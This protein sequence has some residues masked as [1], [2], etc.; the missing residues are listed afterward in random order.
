M[1]SCPKMKNNIQREKRVISMMIGIYCKKKHGPSYKNNLCP[2]CQELQAYAHLRLSHC[3]YGENKGFCSNCPTQCYVQQKKEHIRR[4]MRF[5]GP[6]ML[7]SHP[8]LLVK[9]V[10]AGL[11]K[12]TGK[13]KQAKI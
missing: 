3:R 7:W 12:N 4:V 10:L 1:A 2:E 6:Y 13:S 8:I 5:S 11:P 9:H